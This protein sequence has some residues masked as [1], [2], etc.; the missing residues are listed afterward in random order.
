M[1]CKTCLSLF[2]TDRILDFEDNNNIYSSISFLDRGGLQWPSDMSVSIATVVCNIFQ[3]IIENKA[4]EVLF[5]QTSNQ[6]VILN[7]LCEKK[8]DMDIPE[9]CADCSSSTKS[10]VM[11]FIKPLL[12][13]LLNNYSKKVTDKVAKT[14]NARKLKTY[15]K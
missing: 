6:R 7:L 1:K 9:T 11:D 14:K 12:N 2:C 4:S 8:L 13:I 10:L 15:N 3:S 5:V